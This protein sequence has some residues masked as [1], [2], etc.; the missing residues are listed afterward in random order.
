MFKSLLCLLEHKLLTQ[1]IKDLGL[2][3]VH[4]DPQFG[5]F[6][7]SNLYLRGRHI[8]YGDIPRID[9]P[10]YLPKKFKGKTPHEINW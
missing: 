10:Y 2:K 1:V 9:L 6:S 5:P 8:R 4:F 7:D 3:I